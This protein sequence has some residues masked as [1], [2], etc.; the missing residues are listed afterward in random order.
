MADLAIITPTRGRPRQF[1]DLVETV[2]ATAAGTVEIWAG[3]DDDDHADYA[4]ALGLA[5][6]L[7]GPRRSLSGWTNHL[8][9][10]ALS[11]ENP[12]RYLA[13]LGDD[14]RPRTPGW[15]RILI[16]AIGGLPGG[17]GFA[18]GNDLFQGANMPTAWVVSADVVRAL[19]WMMLPGCAHMYVDNAVLELGRAA[20]RIVYRPD[21]IIEHVHPVAGKAA[22]DDSYRESNA[23]DRY[24]TD[25]AAFGAWRASGLAT[26]AAKLAAL[27][28]PA[29]R[30]VG[31]WR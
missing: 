31:Q 12:P 20:G 25:R 13:S 9:T 1:A 11:S 21:V 4:E 8:A 23:P 3:M 15:D 28:A 24:A 16:D 27:P 19:G 14:H 5:D 7:R 17:F 6:V 18:Y 29:V 2:H 10:Q 26:D 30:E 22:W